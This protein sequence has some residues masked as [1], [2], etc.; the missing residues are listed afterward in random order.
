MFFIEFNA[1]ARNIIT[2]INSLTVMTF[3]S[4]EKKFKYVKNVII[5]YT[6]LFCIHNNKVFDILELFFRPRKRS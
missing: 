2:N 5:V 3:S 4:G 6:L 1:C